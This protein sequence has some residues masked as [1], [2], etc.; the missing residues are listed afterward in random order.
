VQTHFDQKE[1]APH[2]TNYI[3][4]ANPAAVISLLDQIQALEAEVERLTP[5]QF[6]QAPC[7]KFCEATAFNIEIK[8]LRSQID[9]LKLDVKRYLKALKKIAMTEYHIER[10][11]IE[12]L[13]EQMRKTAIAAMKGAA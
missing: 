13:E 3:A 6:R 9:A 1:I 5:L 2:I 11:P 8:Q 10:P 4:A 12:S 7:H